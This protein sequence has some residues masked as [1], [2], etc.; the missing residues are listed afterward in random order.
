MKKNQ[1]ILSFILIA[2]VSLAAFIFL[3]NQQSYARIVN[4]FDEIPS[5]DFFIGGNGKY[6]MSELQ[7]WQRPD[8]P[9]RVGIQSGHWQNQDLPEEI[10][11]LSYNNAGATGGGYNERDTVLVISQKVAARLEAQ[12]IMVDLLP[13]AIP[14]GYLADAF[15]AIHADGNDDRN[16]SGFKTASPSRDFSRQSSV[17]EQAVADEYQRATRLLLDPHVTS[18]MRD[19]YAFNWQKYEHAIHPLTPAMIIET[20]YITNPGD[21]RTIVANSDTA[22]QGIVSGIIKFLVARGL[23]SMAAS[24]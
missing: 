20:G 5:V 1:L 22:A 6:S 23:Y 4:I 17:L 12:G 21:R 16:V 8:G 7:N 10:K 3:K 11:N 9:V 15:V 2:A 24:N 19:Y 18:N 14:P 13:T